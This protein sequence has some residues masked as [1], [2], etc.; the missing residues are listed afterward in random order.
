[1]KLRAYTAEETDGLLNKFT[2]IAKYV[3]E[4]NERAYEILSNRYAEYTENFSWSI[5]KWTP[6]DFD[7][8]TSKLNHWE[9]PRFQRYYID[10]RFD[11]ND[12]FKQDLFKDEIKIFRG[13][14]WIGYYDDFMVKK[15]CT[16]LSEEEFDTLYQSASCVDNFV[17]N[18]DLRKKYTALVKYA[19]KPFEFDE[20]DI[21]WL[22]LIDNLYKKAVEWNSNS[23]SDSP[24]KS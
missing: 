5:F 22:E 2:V 11:E 19:H 17:V 1:M 9:K 4:I 18:Y 21:S 14:S 20:S 7:E 23:T 12:I 13:S 15:G 24:M 16:K 6:I 8:F 3:C 10:Q